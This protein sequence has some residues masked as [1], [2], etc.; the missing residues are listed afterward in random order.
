VRQGTTLPET[1]S[2]LFSARAAWPAWA[3]LVRSRDEDRFK[4]ELLAARLRTLAQELG[5]E[6]ENLYVM[7]PHADSGRPL[8]SSHYDE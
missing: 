7:E 3:M 8:K 2:M 6:A 4:L 1:V 5:C